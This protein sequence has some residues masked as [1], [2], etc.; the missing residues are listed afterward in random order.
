MTGYDPNF[1]TET[2]PLPTFSPTIFGEV[3]HRPELRDGVFADYVHYTVAMH[4]GFRTPLFA[5]LNV[6]QDL[7]KQVARTDRWRIDTRIGRENQ[8]DNA[9]YHR[10]PWDRGHLARRATAAW[11][12]SAQAAK[13]ASDETFYF[14]NAALQH[15]NLN[16][17]EWLAL[18]EWVFNL[19]LDKGNRFSVFSGPVFGEFMRT[20]RPD[21]REPAFVPS[22]FFKII[23]FMNQSDMLEVR[24]FLMP[25]D[26]KALRDKSG[27]RIFDHQIYQVAVGEI[28]RLT[29]LEF[30]EVLPGRN[31]LFYVDRAEV[32]AD[33]N[34]TDFPERREVNGSADIVR[35]NAAPR[36]ITFA[37]DA[38]DVFI[39]AAMVNPAG[40]EREGEW[41][42]IA[43]LTGETVSI[44]GWT[45]VDDKRRVE[46]LTGSIGP[47]E[48]VRIQPLESVR[49]V[50]SRSAFI[51]LLNDRNE[52][53]DRVPYTK[54]QATREGKPIVFA[55]RDLDYDQPAR[56]D[57]LDIDAT[58]ED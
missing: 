8:L 47:G 42:S 22:A 3:L 36:E 48:A 23:F 10:N 35:D 32:R 34:V 15:A 27:R 19:D 44:D 45:L 46:R 53:I 54:E 20:I 1:L 7:H 25:Q 50:N 28:E 33:N 16:Q 43:N 11:G 51:Q 4:R 55:Y 52:Q 26:E 31:P 41:V 18:E 58:A 2:V 38:V 14:S 57:R 56:D 17:D 13:R 9:Y 5:A 29:G 39:A 6:D 21:E 24:A 12:P 37:D 30:P 40:N 49:L